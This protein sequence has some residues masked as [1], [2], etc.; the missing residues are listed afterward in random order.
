MKDIPM[1]LLFNLLAVAQF[2]KNRLQSELR[3][4]SQHS[5]RFSLE[6]AANFVFLQ[7]EQRLQLPSF[8]SMRLIFL[9]IARVVLV[10]LISYIVQSS[11]GVYS[12]WLQVACQ[13]PNHFGVNY[14]LLPLLKTVWAGLKSSK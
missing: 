9:S 7:K 3:G 1:A 12:N 11:N 13:T 4:E 14:C 2:R 6:I 10:T 8:W 5:P